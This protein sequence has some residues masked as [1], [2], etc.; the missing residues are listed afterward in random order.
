MKLT[1]QQAY[2]EANKFDDNMN[3]ALEINPITED[4]AKFWLCYC[5]TIRS[6]CEIVEAHALDVVKKFRV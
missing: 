6:T 3:K 1:N 4:T 2:E 5:R